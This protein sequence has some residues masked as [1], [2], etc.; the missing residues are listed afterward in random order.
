MG[1]DSSIS[2][3][4]RARP[5]S[6]APEDAAAA[7][8]E[9]EEFPAAEETECGLCALLLLLP[10]PELLDELERE[11]AARA[12]VPGDRRRHEDEVGSQQPADD[13]QRDRRALVDDEKLRL[14]EDLMV[15]WSDVLHRLP[16]GAEQVHPNDALGLV[17]FGS[18]DCSTS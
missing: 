9:P 3:K 14:R 16:V 15:T 8:E 17:N 1:S 10:L 6:T 5:P 13:G 7:A 12:L 11:R 4:T 2:R 18:V